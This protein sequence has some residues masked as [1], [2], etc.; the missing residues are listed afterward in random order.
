MS[1]S[2]IYDDAYFD[3]MR[4]ADA[5]RDARRPSL[6]DSLLALV[7]D[8]PLQ[9]MRVLDAGCGRG[10]LTVLLRQAGAA[11]VD[12]VDFSPDAVRRATS[13]VTRS[14]GQDDA[15]R[16]VHG[17]LQEPDVFAEGLFDLVLMID[18]VEHLPGPVLR[19][20]LVNI[21]T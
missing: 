10:E 7:K 14:L 1:T 20:A 8:M 9:N 16:I 2:A 6:Y 4:E 3:R 5:I 15:V 12:G 19:Q 17:S 11:R 18:V 21:G 13:H